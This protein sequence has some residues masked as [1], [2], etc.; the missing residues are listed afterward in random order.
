MARTEITFD[1]ALRAHAAERLLPAEPPHPELDELFAYHTGELAPGRQDAVRRH[2]V[3]CSECAQTVLDMAHF[4]DLAQPEG[5]PAWSPEE[6]AA[7]QQA[8][9]QRLAASTVLPFPSPPAAQ[10]WLPALAA[11]LLAVSLGLG[12][13]VVH[14]QQQLRGTSSPLAGVNVAVETLSAGGSGLRGGEARRVEL[15]PGTDRLVLSL[16]PTALRTFAGHQLVI[17]DAAGDEI[18]R[19]GGLIPSARGWFSVELRPDRLPPGRYQVQV[20]RVSGGEAPP[21]VL[22]DTWIELARAAPSL[23]DS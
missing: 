2:L 9:H 21:E 13:W 6:L 8:L 11:A 23:P 4:P 5:E 17:R 19:S 3:L 14:L 12:F 20:L 1:D 22:V 16:E 10:R 15:P 18:V 7:D